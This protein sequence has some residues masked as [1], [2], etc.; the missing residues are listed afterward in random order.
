MTRAAYGSLPV[1][2]RSV[3]PLVRRTLR[4]E[5]LPG[6]MLLLVPA[7]IVTTGSILIADLEWPGGVLVGALGALV[8]AD[9]LAER[10]ETRSLTPTR[11]HSGRWLSPASP[12][13]WP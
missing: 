13:S 1:D 12:S 7:I 6:A 9:A 5:V 2:L 10:R 8:G 4:T 3:D 11:V